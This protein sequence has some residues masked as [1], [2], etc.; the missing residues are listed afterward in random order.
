MK[1][2]SQLELLY[3]IQEE[4]GVNVVTC[5]TCGDVFFHERH[6]EE[7]KCPH[8]EAEHDPGD[9]PDLYYEGWDDYKDTV[10]E[11]VWYCVCCGNPQGR[12]DMWFEGDICGICDTQNL[13]PMESMILQDIIQNLRTDIKTNNGLH[14]VNGG[15]CNMDFKSCDAHSIFLDYSFGISD[16]YSREVTKGVIELDRDDFDLIDRQDTQKIIQDYEQEEI[17]IDLVRK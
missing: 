12:H 17:I 3:K 8:C 6:E 4:S 10:E 9:C 11:D 1:R 15:F 16:G 5:G 13:S 14:N 2:L 7:L